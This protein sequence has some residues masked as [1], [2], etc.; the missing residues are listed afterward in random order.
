MI[1]ALL[2]WKL[3]LSVCSGFLATMAAYSYALTNKD[4]S[5]QSRI[6]YHKLNKLAIYFMT[7]EAKKQY[8]L[9]HLLFSHV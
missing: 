7:F 4:G 9:L 8:I 2:A 1:F 3:L 5:L 6:D